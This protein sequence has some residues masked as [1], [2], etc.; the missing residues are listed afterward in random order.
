MTLRLLTLLFAF[1]VANTSSS[2]S[3]TGTYTQ[4]V[5]N[6]QSVYQATPV[7]FT[8]TPGNATTGT[9]SCSWLGCQDVGIGNPNIYIQIFLN[10][11]WQ[12]LTQQSGFSNCGFVSFNYQI[13]ANTLNN[14]ILSGGGNVL[15]RV[16]VNDFCPAGM[17]CSCCND[18]YI[19]SLTLSYN[20]SQASFSV[21]DSSVC[22]GESVQFTNTTS[23]TI[24][25]RKWYFPG[26]SPA[27]STA[28]NP[29]VAYAIPGTYDVTLVTTSASGK[30]ST[31]KSAYMTINSPT[32]AAVTAGS[33]TT[34]CQGGQVLLSANTGPGL[35]YQ[36]KKNSTIISG[37]TSSSYAAKTTGNYNVVI[38]NGFGCTSS[39]SQ[40]AVTSN[41]KPTAILSAVGNTTFCPGDSSYYLQE[42]EVAIAMYG[43]KV[44][45]PLL[46]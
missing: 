11:S 26:G 17:G 25:S 4:S 30:D 5:P 20:Y 6:M 21:S 33:S 24:T 41:L 27:T 22:P 44:L 31:V 38:T 45:L 9:L 13:P 23:G 16:N 19:N 40:V 12:L 18:P 43:K 2:F 32:Q 34:F 37:A 36:W 29:T 8:G 7:T 3:Q 39:S 10:G 14:A 28:N 42:Q 35:T 15:L 46:V 1:L